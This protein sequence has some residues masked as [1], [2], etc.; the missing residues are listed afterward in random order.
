MKIKLLFLLCLLL[1][2]NFSFA[3]GQEGL[4]NILSFGHSVMV[5]TNLIVYIFVLGF[6]V[7]FLFF[8]GN[9]KN[10]YAKSF[11]ISSLISILL[12]AIFKDEF[13]FLIFNIL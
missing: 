3:E 12:L 10:G 8:K 2:C 5:V 13:T 1:C 4:G 11:T 9:S 6:L 7:K